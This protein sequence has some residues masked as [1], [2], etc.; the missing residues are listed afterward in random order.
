MAQISHMGFYESKLILTC[1]FSVPKFRNPYPLQ[2]T[3]FSYIS[4]N[5]R[6]PCLKIISIL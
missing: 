4:I 1:S 6:I 2:G 3:H 5:Q